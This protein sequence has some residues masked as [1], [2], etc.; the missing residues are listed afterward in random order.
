MCH[1]YV[2]SIDLTG[3]MSMDYP[4]LPY[5][6]LISPISLYL[7]KVSDTLGSTL[8]RARAS[9]IPQPHPFGFRVISPPEI[10]LNFEIAALYCFFFLCISFSMP[11]LCIFLSCRLLI[12]WCDVGL[13]DMVGIRTWTATFCS[14]VRAGWSWLIPCWLMETGHDMTMDD[15]RKMIYQLDQLW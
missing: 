11:L 5:I 2:K 4:T 3:A 10:A 15:H 14:F 9:C 1:L 8:C 6:T 7:L 13:V 12:G